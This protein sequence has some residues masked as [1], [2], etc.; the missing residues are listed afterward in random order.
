MRW[1]SNIFTKILTFVFE[2]KLRHWNSYLDVLYI[3]H[4]IYTLFRQLFKFNY[5]PESTSTP[6]GYLAMTCFC[7]ATARGE[8][9]TRERKGEKERQK[10]V[11]GSVKANRFPGVCQLHFPCLVNAVRNVAKSSSRKTGQL[12]RRRFNQFAIS[13]RATFRTRDSS[14]Q[15]HEKLIVTKERHIDILINYKIIDRP[16]F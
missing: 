10:L 9:I 12:W 3:K 15:L 6:S 13:V 16:G 5:F 8:W 1:E 11:H 14:T 7:Y 2:N 4:V